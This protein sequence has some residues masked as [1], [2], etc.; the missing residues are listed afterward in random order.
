[1]D[2]ELVEHAKES[3]GRAHGLSAAQSKRL[4]G[5][6]SEALHADARVMA[7]ELGVTDP[8]LQKRD[9][10]GRY[11]G[12]ERVDMNRAIRQAAGR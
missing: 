2:D 11:A 4:V 1:M 10:Q 5:S 7:S 9:E 6:T 8:T 12:G 3:I